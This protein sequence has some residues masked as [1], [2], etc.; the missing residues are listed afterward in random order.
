MALPQTA[1]DFVQIQQQWRSSSTMAERQDLA[2]RWN[3]TYEAAYAVA[4]EGISD[5]ESLAQ[6][7]PQLAVVSGRGQRE[8]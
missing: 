6:R 5:P 2:Q 8:R 1:G 4:E 7:F 3:L